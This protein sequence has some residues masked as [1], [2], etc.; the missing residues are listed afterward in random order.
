[1]LMATYLELKKQ[2]DELQKEADSVRAVERKD[3][4]VRIKEAIAAYDIDASELGLS[5]RAKDRTPSTRGASKK[6]ASK[7]ARLRKGE[8]RGA[9]AYSDSDGNTWG[10]RGKRPNWLREAL[11]KGS[12]LEDFAV[13]NKS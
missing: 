6:S 12:K 11:A 10:G 1:M 5:L 3:V 2:I 8:R 4:I 9:A 7:G 13:A